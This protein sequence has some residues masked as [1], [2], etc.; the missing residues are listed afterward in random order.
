MKIAMIS[1]ADVSGGGA[2]KVATQLTKELNNRGVYIDHF[3]RSS[4]GNTQTIS[5]YT[6]LEKKIYHRLLDIGIQEYFPFEYKVIKKYDKI[7]EYD[8][9]HFH[10][11]T[12][13]VSPLTIKKLSDNGKNI[14]WTIH[15]CSVVTGGCIYP[16]DCKQYLTK[17]RNCPQLNSFGLGRNVDLTFIFHTIKKYIL[18]N[19]NIHFIAPSKWIADL[20]YNTGYIKNYPTI[21]PNSVDTTI[22]K[23]LDKK[24]SRMLLGLEINRF[25][26]LISSANLTNKYKGLEHAVKILHKVKILNPYILVVGKESRDLLNHLQ[27][28]DTF[29]TGYISDE[30]LLNKYYASADI[31]LNTTIADNH[32]LAVLETMAS[33]TPNIGFATGGIPEIITHGKDG[34]ISKAQNIDEIA[35]Q[36]IFYNNNK[37]FFNIMSENAVSKIIADY[38][39]NKFMDAHINFYK[40]ILL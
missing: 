15:D 20:I 17:C 11:I 38:S 16:L 1:K 30:A 2:S 28:F 32:P 19:S 21:I 40:D 18:R 24:S 37:N 35:N 10:D 25:I 9:F 34:Y 36:I 31:F 22:F 39:L 29:F 4:I 26:I 8:I 14:V 5:L 33:G 23:H 13:T 6:N 7:K 12:S 3:T 27:G